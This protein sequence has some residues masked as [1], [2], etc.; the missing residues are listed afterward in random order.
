MGCTPNKSD[1][2]KVDDK[3]LLTIEQYRSGAYFL[4]LKNKNESKKRKDLKVIL[5]VISPCK[6]PVRLRKK[7]D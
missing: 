1:T 4:A 7:T 3:S 2:S 5:S 6:T